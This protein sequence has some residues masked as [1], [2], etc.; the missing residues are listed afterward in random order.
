[1]KILR[2]WDVRDNTQMTSEFRESKQARNALRY[3]QQRTGIEGLATVVADAA[4]GEVELVEVAHKVGSV[5][6][7]ECAE[8][9]A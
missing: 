1:M 2:S 5:A 9:Q 6:M 8:A 3:A 7:D 4:V